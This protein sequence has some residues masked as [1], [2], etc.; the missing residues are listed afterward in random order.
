MFGYQIWISFE[1]VEAIAARSAARVTR[2]SDGLA[3]KIEYNFDLTFLK[4]TNHL[5][6]APPVIL[7]G[8]S[9]FR[10]KTYV[11]P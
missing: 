3:E 9:T 4:I 7:A 8:A 6:F 1:G 5:A 11:G 10:Q 2:L